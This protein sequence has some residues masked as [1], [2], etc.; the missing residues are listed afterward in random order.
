MLRPEQMSKVS[1]AGSRTV[2]REVIEAIHDLQLVHFSDYDG[3]IEGFETGTPLSGAEDAA[4]R[5]VTVRSLKNTLGVTE[6]DAGPT[7]IVSD[8][9]IDEELPTVREAVNEFD[10]RRS[11]IRDE[12]R[13]VEDA[14]EAAEPFVHLGIDLEL[15]AGYG[16]LEVAV[17]E[18]DA[19]E[20]SA[21]L[22]GHDGV[23]AYGLESSNG[24]VAAFVYPESGVSGALDDAIVGVEFDP[25]EVPDATGDP[26]TYVEELEHRRE[27]L[28]SRLNSVENELEELRLEY[29]G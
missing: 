6:E 9:D 10:D 29:A 19:E 20:L 4:D 23:E 5:L 18:G 24:V 15:L 21:A 2:I 16:T 14:I 7:R 12:L 1:M 3:T 26:A 17:G 22:D 11:A 28:E 27:K 25:L 8:A 13:S